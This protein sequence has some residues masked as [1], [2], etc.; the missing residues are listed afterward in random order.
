LHECAQS[1]K[2]GTNEAI[3]STAASFPGFTTH[4]NGIVASTVIEIRARNKGERVDFESLNTELL[5][6]LEECFA[7]DPDVARL[8]RAEE[9][10]RQPYAG[11][12]LSAPLRRFAGIGH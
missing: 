7:F 4:R 8:A 12:D 11:D 1:Q 6:R 5:G 3:E 9:C 2:P 10:F